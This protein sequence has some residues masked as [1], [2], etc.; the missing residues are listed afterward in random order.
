MK[1]IKVAI[2]T[3]IICCTYYSGASGQHYKSF[4]RYYGQWILTGSLMHASEGP[5]AAIE[6]EKY[7]GHTL[8]AIRFGLSYNFK[9]NTFQ[10]WKIP[11]HSTYFNA[12]YYY[13]LEKEMSP[14]FFINVGGG[15]FAGFE[16]P[17]SANLP[18]G[19]IQNKKTR[20]LYGAR[21]NPQAE[22]LFR[23]GASVTMYIEPQLAF[24]FNTNYDK[25]IWAIR[26][27]AKWYL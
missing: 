15:L 10:D 2:L 1:I 26:I 8:S 7:I 21:I 18:F 23:R 9:K 11:V 13:S 27:G 14:L 17:G 3:A 22:I 6:A 5:G 24:K 25:L 19:V 20:F 12:S 4:N 16:T